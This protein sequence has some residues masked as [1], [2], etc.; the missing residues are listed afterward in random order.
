[1]TSAGE[2]EQFVYC[3]HNWWLAQN[4][5]VAA[6]AAVD[7]G[8]AQHGKLGREQQAVED[9]KGEARRAWKWAWRILVFAV[10]ATLVTLQ[11]VY[12]AAFEH[13][14]IF[15]ALTAV[16]AVGSIGL[17]LLNDI[18]RRRY[19]SRQAKAGLIPGK[20]VASDLSGAGPLLHDPVLDLRG[21]PDYVLETKSGFVPVEVKTG[22]TPQHPH[23]NHRAQLA[24]YLRLV[25]VKTGKA[26]EYGLLNY[27]DGV[28]RVAN[29][30][31]LQADLRTTLDRIAQ[32]RRDGK[33]DR[34]HQ[35]AGRCVGCARRSGCEQKLA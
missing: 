8:V 16:L 10:A 23:D 35:H 20:L 34:D 2:V 15:I 6:G 25:E 17:A 21:R 1:M 18:D 5:A 4:G 32:A 11:F 28:F 30:A 26:P 27:P 31:T 14:I 29:D 19:K 13:Q 7:Q 12:N 9:L 22:K 24:C 33:A 3:P